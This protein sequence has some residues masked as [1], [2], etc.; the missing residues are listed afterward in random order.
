MSLQTQSGKLVR[1]TLSTHEVSPNM[2]EYTDQELREVIDKNVALG[3]LGSAWT[4]CQV[5]LPG[6]GHL[7]DSHAL[8]KQES[9]YFLCLVFFNIF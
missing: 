8:S 9:S 4:I 2:T 6:S 3:R 7:D 5:R 1:L